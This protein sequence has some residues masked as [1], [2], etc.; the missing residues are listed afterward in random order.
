MKTKTKNQIPLHTEVAKQKIVAWLKNRL[1]SLDIRFDRDEYIDVPSKFFE[2]LSEEQTQAICSQINEHKELPVM[3]GR[4]LDGLA[5]PMVLREL[6]LGG[7]MLSELESRINNNIQAV[8]VHPTLK[9]PLSEYKDSYVIGGNYLFGEWQGFVAKVTAVLE[10]PNI[11]LH[12]REHPTKSELTLSVVF[13]VDS[14]G[15]VR[16]PRKEIVL[17]GERFFNQML[18]GKL[19]DDQL[20]ALKKEVKLDPQ[21]LNWLAEAIYV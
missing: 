5:S 3:V 12:Q 17:Y 16:V 18:L 21:T 14:T 13:Y 6:G 20:N 15:R 19:T 4:H 1:E 2:G 9:A 10:N 11:D 8:L 7:T